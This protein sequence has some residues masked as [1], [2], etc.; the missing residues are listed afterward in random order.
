MQ[1]LLVEDDKK[2]N[3][4]IQDYLEHEGYVCESALSFTEAKVKLAKSYDYDL[5]ILDLCLPDGDGV[6]LCRFARQQNFQTPILMLSSRAATKDKV[7]GLDAGADDYMPKPFSPQELQARIRALLRRPPVTIGE[8]I[9]CGDISINVLAHSVRKGETLIN[10][11]PKEYALLE[12]LIRKKDA[13]VKKEELLRHVWGVYSRTS[14][15]RLEV[16]IRYLREKLDIPY[17]TNYIQTVRGLGYKI[18]ED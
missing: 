3:K 4:I 7:T 2:L 14:S 9:Q 10:L 1:I 15:N 12:Y 16:Y 11:M 18:A 6:D 13:V 8:E 5:V 17:N